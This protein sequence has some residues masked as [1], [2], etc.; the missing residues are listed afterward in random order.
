MA[1]R[2]YYYTTELIE[3][4]NDNKCG[5]WVNRRSRRG[6]NQLRSNV[7]KRNRRNSDIYWGHRPLWST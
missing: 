1:K 4:A 5:Y 2:V 7:H 6:I 3:V